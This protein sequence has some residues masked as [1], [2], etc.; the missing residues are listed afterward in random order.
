MSD[1]PPAS[2]EGS[3][4]PP[5]ENVLSG[6]MRKRYG[7]GMMFAL[8]LWPFAG[9]YSELEAIL[10]NGLLLETYRQLVFVAFVNTIAFFL[11]S[12]IQR[13]LNSRVPGKWWQAIFGDGT[14]PWTR[15]QIVGTVVASA[16]TPS[17][18]AMFFAEDFSAS[19]GQHVIMSI[20][21]IGI[22]LGLGCLL[23]ILVSELK[24]WMFG[25]DAKT[26]NYF[27]FEARDRKC[28]KFIKVAFDII[29]S[30]SKT[31]KLDRVASWL[32]IERIDAQF[33][34][35]LLVLALL[36][37]G[38][39]GGIGDSNSWLTS[40]PAMVVVLIWI[41]GMVFSGIANAFDRFRLPVVA[42][43]VLLL[44]IW[45]SFSGST[46]DLKTFAD[47]SNNRFVEKVAAV[48]KAESDFLSQPFDERKTSRVELIRQQTATLED[49]A[50]NAI[51]K[52]MGR[53]QPVN[54]EKGKTLVVV[55]CP[56]GGIHAAAWSACV[57]DR[58]STEYAE[59]ADSTCL[60]SGVSGGSVGTL[61]FVSSQY[62]AALTRKMQ[63]VGTSM[64]PTT[65]ELHD[66]IRLKSPALDL[67]ARSSLEHI[68]YGITTDDL[69][70]LIHS[71]LTSSDR[72][73]RLGDSLSSCQPEDQKDLT[74]GDWGDRAV[75]GTVPIVVFNSTDAVSGRRIL[76]D[77]IPTPRRG[78][79]VGKTS[80]P[81]N[82]REL[83]Y[84]N[85]DSA[86][87]VRPA[88]A[89]RT[90]ATFPFV[91]PFTKPKDGS[92]KGDAVA[93]CDGGYVDNE[94]IVSA[95]NWIDFLIKRWAVLEPDDRPFDRVL[96]LRIEPSYNEDLGQ[97][98]DSGG[99]AGSLRWLAG[100]A[101]AMV[102]VRAASQ[103]ERGNLESDLASQIHELNTGEPRSRSAKTTPSPPSLLGNPKVQYAPTGI[104]TVVEQSIS[105]RHTAS[106]EA[107]RKEWSALVDDYQ[108]RLKS[109]EDEA[110]KT[111]R[112]QGMF[113][114]TPSDEIEHERSSEAYELPVVVQAI[115]FENAN[116]V[117][118]L[119]WKLSKKQKVWYLL[120]WER[121]CGDGTKLKATLSRFFTEL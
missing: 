22:G 5:T 80:R 48:G 41:A 46:S 110:D 28:P 56:G 21:Y 96:L 119:N 30:V 69:Y 102:N 20:V 16:I 89:A 43:M 111:P 103:L 87:D 115:R 37:W 85:N 101:E 73:Q 116:Q 7:I 8:M 120:A 33:L 121:C 9:F 60:I 23:L 50:W 71:S 26:Q 92:P 32:G 52:R 86:F 83:M 59:F 99:L 84:V 49:A 118:P 94:G 10:R 65:V 91:S 47:K 3:K 95:V 38:S 108:E 112:V 19:T 113:R 75:E 62:D 97:I 105:Q 88:T 114:P 13:L 15:M 98:P 53:V 2:A 29:G 79:S 51:V 35:Y 39:S 82:Y 17:L 58:I 24:C 36:H 106:P 18:L 42:I 117:I 93:I 27:P 54:P 90:S 14:K 77:S 81:L 100:P 12:S 107:N 1:S 25:S 70:G 34:S 63:T 67:S 57:L 40:A 76:F 74:L 66:A 104:P 72:G 6:L 64:P 55:T 45:L 4:Q 31:T 109:G 78:S 44:T 11:G 68:A 61:M